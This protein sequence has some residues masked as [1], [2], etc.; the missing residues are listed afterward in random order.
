MEFLERFLAGEIPPQ[1]FRHAD[2]VRAGYELLRTRE[3]LDAAKIYCGVLKQ[4]TARIGKP[5]VFHQTV[6]LAFLALI[7]ERMESGR[8]QDFQ[9]FADA[10]PDLMEK[11]ALARWYS[12]E[13]LQAPFARRSFALPD[14][15]P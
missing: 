7:A 14:R 11:S 8:E 9:S 15:A 1:N 10:N 2:H 4:M 12:P 13:K 5:E 3:F 6:T